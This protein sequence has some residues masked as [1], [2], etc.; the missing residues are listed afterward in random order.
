[1]TPV[2]DQSSRLI[3]LDYDYNHD[4][5]VDVRTFMKD[6]RPERLEGDADGDGKTDRWEYYDAAG[7]VLRVGGSTKHD[8]VEDTWAYGSGD[9]VRVD[10]STRRNG[11]VD[12][13]EFYNRDVL[14]R[15]ESDTNLDGLLDTWEQYESGRLAVLLLDDTKTESKPKARPTRKLVY[16][17]AGS[18]RVEID[19]DGDGVFAP[20]TT[21]GPRATR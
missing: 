14:E 2:Y 17:R 19:P 18:P 15:T 11:I 6:G 7:A 16:S 10:L 1:V 8:G 13:R 21:P 5:Q 4:G 12:R 9:Q 3:R 20:M